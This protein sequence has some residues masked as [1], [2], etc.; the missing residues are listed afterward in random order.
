MISI[1]ICSKYSK[2]NCELE[3]NI[4]NTI[5]NMPF[6]IITINNSQNSY[7][8]YQAYNKGIKEAKYPYLCFMHEDILFHTV[9]WGGGD[10]Q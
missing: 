7:S 9:N 10:N 3:Q 2:I 5:G 8:I 1:I 4:E 6:E